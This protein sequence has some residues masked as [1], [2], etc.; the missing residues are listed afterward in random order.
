MK[1][2][3]AAKV[4]AAALSFTTALSM[5]PGSAFAGDDTTTTLYGSS[6]VMEMDGTYRDYYAHVKVKV[7]EKGSIISVEDIDT[8]TNVARFAPDS[9]SYWDNFVKSKGFDLFKGKTKETLNDVQVNAIS[10]STTSTRSVKKAILAAFENE[11]HKKKILA[12][13]EAYGPAEKYVDKDRAEAERLI[14]EVKKKIKNEELV[15]NARSHFMEFENKIKKL[16]T[17]DQVKQEEDS[18]SSGQKVKDAI[19]ALGKVSI[20]S[21]AD[22]EKARKMYNALDSKGKETVTAEVY[23]K[24]VDAEEKIF[25]WFYENNHKKLLGSCQIDSYGY[26]VKLAVYVSDNKIVKIED[27]G[28]VESIKKDEH[29]AARN[30]MYWNQFIPRGG[31]YNFIGRTIDDY[32]KVDSIANATYTSDATKGA[33]ADALKK[34]DEDKSV[35]QM[36]KDIEE[37]KKQ[38]GKDSEEQ[39]KKLEKQYDELS[40]EGKKSIDKDGFKNE[41]EVL[42]DKFETLMGRPAQKFTDETDTM[43]INGDSDISFEEGMPVYSKKK[44]KKLNL[45]LNRLTKSDLSKVYVD[46]KEIEDKDFEIVGSDIQISLKKAFL[47]KLENKTHS[48]KID[49][50]RGY[51]ET[52][53]K[54]ES[55]EGPEARNYTRK[56]KFIYPDGSD[57]AVFTGAFN[58][59][60]KISE[61]NGKATYTIAFKEVGMM[62][63]TE[64]QEKITVDGKDYMVKPGKAPYISEFTFTRA[65]L[66]EDKIP[67]R[68]YS[69]TM[70]NSYDFNIVFVGDKTEIEPDKKPDTE[71]PDDKKPDAEKPDDKKPGTEKPDKGTET[72]KQENVKKYFEV[73]GKFLKPNNTEMKLMTEAFN[74]VIKLVEE[75]G[76]ATYT[77]SFKEA[78][79]MGITE[80]LA[81]IS[82]DGKEILATK[83]EGVYVAAFSFTRDKLNEKEIPIKIYI[84]AMKTWMDG[85]V[86]LSDE[87]TETKAPETEPGKEINPINPGKSGEAK[88]PELKSKMNQTWTK[89][90]KT[91]LVFIS[92]ADI[93]SFVKVLLDGKEL[94]RDKEYTVVSGSTKVTLLPETLNKLS[95]GVHNLEIVS[96]NGSVVSKFTIASNSSVKA[97]NTGDMNREI[98]FV[99]FGLVGSALVALILRKKYNKQ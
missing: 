42:R 74:P 87:K 81:K 50:K 84:T 45:R 78:G 98:P 9:K 6:P 51:A 20:Y 59:E 48:L 2:R 31:L 92:D 19:N 82:V 26:F 33:I 64:K 61:K 54:V 28:T 44:S 34:L 88:K 8:S 22:V 83:G 53:F 96:T 41:L 16:K 85:K 57:S 56:A 70:G 47:D 30:M 35:S 4:L 1:K 77:I 55:G 72:G 37:L 67:V 27:N 7:D 86:V 94:L 17:Q 18:K 29:L 49:T 39:L 90:S 21:K 69:K 65:K 43:S 93:S 79:M 89:G 32:N 52:K 5:I 60:V 24:L 63:I 97:P 75:N 11:E 62:S 68:V 25:G 14:N 10:Q 46:G 91:G 23:E 13:V 95:V 38:L 73:K 80:S 36:K 99:A 40:D 76:K 15:S 66:N 3:R 12:Q 58:P 71:K